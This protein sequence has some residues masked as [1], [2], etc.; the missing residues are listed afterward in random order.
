M[1]TA[2]L[3]VYDEDQRLRLSAT[4]RITRKIGQIEVSGSG[5]ISVPEFKLSE[6]FFFI[7]K[8]SVGSQP[9]VKV[10]ADRLNGVL[11]WSWEYFQ[12]PAIGLEYPPLT[13]VYGVY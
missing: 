6:P 2:G 5:S 12:E 7:Q 8:K 9:G 11:S 4:N 13:I 3:E 10:L 1:A